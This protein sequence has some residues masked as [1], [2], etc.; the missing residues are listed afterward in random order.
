MPSVSRER[1]LPYH[2][3]KPPC[4]RRLQQVKEKHM[5]ANTNE[6]H[7][8]CDIVPGQ[9]AVVKKLLTQGV[10]RRRLIDI[11][12]TENTCVRCVGR[13]PFGDPSAYM[14]RGA[15]IAIRREDAGEI[16]V[17]RT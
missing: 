1:R 16:I 14:I 7:T 3:I 8:L 11:G 2:V 12:L 15:V 17:S 5:T 4:I 9:S 13:S 6:V 10:M